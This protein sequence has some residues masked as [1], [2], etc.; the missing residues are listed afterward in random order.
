MSGERIRVEVAAPY[1]VVIGRD[2][3]GD[4]PTWLPDTGA[5]RAAV[6]TTAAVETHHAAPV[7]AGLRAAGLDVH[8]R[9]VPDGEPAKSLDVL[10]ALYD[11]LASLPLARGDVVVALGGGVVTD[12]GGFL[13]ATWH[14]GVA[15]IQVPT[16]LLAQVDAAIGGKTGINLAAG[17]N[18]VGA[19]HQPLVVVADITALDTL[20]ARELRAGMAEVVKCGFIRDPVILEMIETDAEAALDRAGDV[21]VDLVRRAVTV[22]A[23]VVAADTHELG[24]RALLNYGHTFGHALETLTGYTRYRHGEAVGI[25]MRY[26][27]RVAELA[28]VGEDGLEVRTVGLLERLGLPT[29]CAPLDTEAVFATMWRDKKVRDGLRLVLC[30]RPGQ[31]RVAAAPDRALLEQALATVWDA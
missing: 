7:E 9:C 12:L 5:R 16:T 15:V 25:G 21:L 28:G 31:A 3:L 13:A 22:K 19:F 24:E 6:V 2:L 4:A 17:K 27:A 26:A 30:E 29:T 20:P 8:T 10:G 18:L 1:D 23:R 11:W 14:R